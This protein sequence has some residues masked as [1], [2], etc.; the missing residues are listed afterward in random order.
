MSLLKLVKYILTLFNQ[1]KKLT[2][3]L[4]RKNVIDDISNEL[5]KLEFKS[6][7]SIK[8]KCLRYVVTKVLPVL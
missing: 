2:K 8:T 1:Q 3:K 6:S 4:T 7:N 5:L